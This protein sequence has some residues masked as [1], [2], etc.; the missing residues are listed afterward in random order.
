M[1]TDFERII[2][3]FAT[4]FFSGGAVLAA[5]CAAQTTQPYPYISSIEDGQVLTLAP[6]EFTLSYDRPVRV[7]AISLTD[8]DGVVSRLDAS[9]T[10]R[11]NRT[12]AVEMP[13]LKPHRYR[14]S[15]TGIDQSGRSFSGAV[16]FEL[17]GCVEN[18]T[19]AR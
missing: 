10:Q 18:N 12:L 17:L 15:W 1:M 5:P 6:F 2:L 3:V 16:R 11:F 19:T 7:S 9:Y 8:Q 14:L 13:I 4:A